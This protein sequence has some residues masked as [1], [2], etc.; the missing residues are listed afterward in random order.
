MKATFFNSGAEF[1]QWLKENAARS[2]ELWVGYFKA[3]S[4]AEVLIEQGLMRSP[5]L[6]AYQARRENRSGVYSY[7]QRPTQLPEP[8]RSIL[9]SNGPAFKF[10]SV[11]PASYRRAAI[12]WVVSAKKD[13][14]RRRRLKQLIADSARGERI[15]QFLK[16]S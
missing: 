10:F 12:W 4:G 13:E 6:A 16:P 9:E 3:G 1:R 7:E 2:T 15:R 5:G 14:T 8:F 11:Q